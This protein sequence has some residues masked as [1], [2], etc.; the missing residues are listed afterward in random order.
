[1][2]KLVFFNQGIEQLSELIEA[3]KEKPT[4]I[5]LYGYPCHGKTELIHRVQARFEGEKVILGVNP[6][7]KTL[8]HAGKFRDEVDSYIFHCAWM[9]N[10]ID[11]DKKLNYD[12]NG[13]AEEL[14][15]KKID[16]NALVYNP[17]LMGTPNL[18]LDLYDLIIINPESKRKFS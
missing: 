11:T 18:T 9:R 3:P 6:N 15:R 4:L 8:Q 12:P 10:M 13:W 1:M 16:L 7:H 2:T 17:N 5:T 14:F